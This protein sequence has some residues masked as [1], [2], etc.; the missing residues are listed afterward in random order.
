MK[1]LPADSAQKGRQLWFAI[2]A[3]AVSG[4]L[5]LCYVLWSAYEESWQDAEAE[6]SRYVG[7]IDARLSARL[8]RLDTN[9]ALVADLLPD[10]VMVPGTHAEF[11]N[12]FFATW[13]RH[14]EVFPE[15]LAY[16]VFSPS[17]ESLFA[18]D[19]DPLAKPPDSD[20]MAVLRDSAS[21]R[22]YFSPVIISPADNNARILAY[23]PLRSINGQFLGVLSA[24]V[25]LGY[26]EAVFN[27]LSLAGGALVV[28][29]LDSHALLVRSPRL[30]DQ[31]NATL[32]TTNLLVQDV[33]KGRR[34]GSVRVKAHVDGV[35][36]I[37]V[38][39]AMDKYP[40]YVTVGLAKAAVNA[41]WQA[42]ALWTGG[43]A[44]VLFLTL[45]L[46]LIWLF[47]KQ[48]AE[49]KNLE[50]LRENR[51]Q[52]RD[53][54]RLARVGS[55]E[56]DL[57]SGELKWSEELYQI[58][59]CNPT[60]TVCS[61]ELF[62][63]LVHPDDREAVNQAY[64]D[65]L[66]S[67][68][69]YE[70]EH[71]LAMPD[72]RI[73]TILECA[74]TYYAEDGTPLR[75]VGTAQDISSIRQME[76]QMQLLGVAFQHSGEA[77]L[78]TDREN[79]IVTVNPAFTALTGYTQADAL[80]RNPS[81]LSAGRNSPQE[82]AAMWQAIM[83][84]GFWQ[85]EIWDRRKDGGVYPKWMTVSLIRDDEGEIR[86]HI[87]HFTD[88]SL[89]RAAEEKLHHIAHHDSL[90]GLPNRLSLN[91]RID[92]ALSLAR[93]DGGRVALLFI[94]LDRFKVVND[95]LGHHV[96]D[97]L[98]IEVA[99]RLKEIVRDSD[100]VAR[101]GGDEFVVVLT[102]IE[103]STVVGMLAEKMVL[104]IGSPYIIEGHD[105]YTSPSIGIAIFP[106]DGDSSHVLMK[107]AD[108]AMYHAKSAGRNNFQFFDAK[109]NQAAVERL[110]IEHGLRQALANDEF[111]LYF[112]P[113]IEARTGRVVEV[114]ALVRWL[115]PQEGIVP[116]G[117]FIGV[118]EESGLIQPLG[119][120]VFWAACR[121]LAEFNRLGIV[122]VKMGV[123]ISAIQMRNGNLPILA[124]GALE[125]L[126]LNP[127]D[128]VFEITESAAMQHPQ[129]TVAILDLLHDMG[130][131]LAIDDFG[132]GYSS[133]SY[134]K[135]FP[136]DYLKLDRSF[137]EEIGQDDGG[138][139]ICDAT[140]ALTHNLGLKL[141]AE[142]VET[143]AQFTYLRER[144]CDLLQGFF[145]CRPVPADE[146][147]E[148]IRL[149][150]T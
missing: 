79:R 125:A 6:A 148:F 88:I 119:E 31:Y 33:L 28:R 137:V 20:L 42:R 23:R 5:L 57:L 143:E 15:V 94:D 99:R 100:V 78:I 80:G 127:A 101:L 27:N 4:V 95:T 103:H 65:S 117:R 122:D 98:L 74:Q 85:G 133:L 84:K 59:E 21:P 113:V 107:N 48:A 37:Y 19:L 123:N 62:L 24:V 53:A 138:S 51:E 34:S 29:R 109:M 1:Q 116:P 124:R 142:G 45:S 111:C 70:I 35:E 9:L 86:Y 73:K 2:V 92:Q 108:A 56:L 87:A 54:Q 22:I 60:N 129:E 58:F 50:A 140:I 55:W 90:T 41:D 89:E 76:S 121:Q 14:Y 146:V 16:Q 104:T 25:D 67:R 126:G 40:L 93:R 71:R 13:R 144:D 52:L 7:I 131:L 145:F 110:K 26:F 130:V 149:R 128:L 120:W 81:F 106:T 12:S 64:L 39:Q 77:I 3:L 139:V 134:L 18:S 17:G 82:Y 75:S 102:G 11:H 10:K 38:Y 68:L 49:F 132:T 83:E 118:A 32:P 61:Y 69:A 96:G 141:V 115:H 8:N 47:R 135:M 46:V 72:G 114:E 43:L 63:E 150:N 36:R 66:E 112:Q 91:G 30:L 97:E 147:I 136:I 105:L 44:G